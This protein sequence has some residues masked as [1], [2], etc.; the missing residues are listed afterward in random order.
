MLFALDENYDEAEFKNFVKRIIRWDRWIDEH[1][2]DVY[3][4]SSTEKIL[5][6]LNSAT[7]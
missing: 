1:P 5:S 2:N 6:D 4:L 3:I 7:L